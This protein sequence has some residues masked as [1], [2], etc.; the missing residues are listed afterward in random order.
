MYGIKVQFLKNKAS[1]AKTQHA[2]K[3]NSHVLQTILFKGHSIADLIIVI[4]EK[5]N[6]SNIME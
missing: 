2:Y 1:H 5:L 4:L 3:S 6:F